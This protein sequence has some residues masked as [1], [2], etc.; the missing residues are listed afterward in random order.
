VPIKVDNWVSDFVVFN[1]LARNQ[2]DQGVGRIEVLL[3]DLRQ[4][5]ICP[6][7][8]KK[9]MWPVERMFA[10]DCRGRFLEKRTVHLAV[11]EDGHSHI[12]DQVETSSMAVAQLAAPWKATTTEF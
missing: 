5:E 9:P 11:R 2:L 6:T 10:L 12:V 1:L 3:A 4:S 8:E 7:S